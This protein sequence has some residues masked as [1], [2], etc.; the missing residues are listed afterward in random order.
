MNAQTVEVTVKST[1][2]QCNT[3]TLSTQIVAYVVAQQYWA[4]KF[5]EYGIK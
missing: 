5:Q 1:S 4:S 2:N 3:F